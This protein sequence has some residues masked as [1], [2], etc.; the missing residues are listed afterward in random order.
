MYVLVKSRS[1]V[2]YAIYTSALVYIAKFGMQYTR[3]RYAFC[4]IHEWVCDIHECGMNFAIYTSAVCK[5][6]YAIYKVRFAIY[7]SAL[8]YIAKFN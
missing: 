4:N 7:T 1:R 5:I 8:V 3:V 6:Q 2:R